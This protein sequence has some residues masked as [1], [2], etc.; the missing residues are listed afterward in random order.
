M[1]AFDDFRKAIADRYHV[2]RE[3]G[4]GGMATVYLAHDLRHDRPV[5]LKLL[6]PELGAV[7][8][9]ER[10]LREIRL[11]AKLQHPHILPL[12]DSGGVGGG[13]GMPGPYLFYVMPY[14][15]GESLRQLLERDKQLSIAEALR[16][17]TEIAE[18][19][20]YAHQQAVIHRDIKPEN[21]LLSQGHA[22][23]A[24]FGIALAVTQA[25]GGRL[26]ETGLSLGTPAYMSPEQA[27][28]EADLD[29]RTDQYSLACVLYEMLAGEPPYSGPTAQAIIAKRLREPVPHLSTIREVPAAVEMAVTRALAKAR[30]DRFSSCAEF[31]KALVA[32]AQ[33]PIRRR[34]SILAAAALVLV[35]ALV[36]ILKSLPHHSGPARPAP[37]SKNPEAQRLNERGYEALVRTS[38]NYYSTVD[39]DL[40]D[41]AASLFSR[42]AELDTTFGLAL[43]RLAEVESRRSDTASQTR[44]RAAATQAVARSP[45]LAEAHLALL[46]VASDSATAVAE[47]ARA[48]EL[49]PRNPEV[50]GRA[51]LLT[52]IYGGSDDE[53]NALLQR[54]LAADSAAFEVLIPAGILALTEGRYDE[55]GERFRQAI[56]SR[57]DS[58]DGYHWLAWRWQLTGDQL[59]SDS[60]FQQF[61]ARVGS[62]RAIELASGWPFFFVSFP[63]RYDATV[64]S[65]VADPRRGPGT[66]HLHLSRGFVQRRL[67]NT[68][69][70][71]ASFDSAVTIL[72]KSGHLPMLAVAQAAAGHAAVAVATARAVMDGHPLGIRQRQNYELA[73]IVAHAYVL[74]HEPD[75][76]I[77]ILER[78]VKGSWLVTPM[79]LRVDPFWAPLQSNFRFQQLVA[80]TG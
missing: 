48:L 43:A 67:G 77:D 13:P 22:L 4:A 47:L 15:E 70:A 73:Y 21:I 35:M 46:A 37:L 23:V 16:L 53:A 64:L 68:R 59:R 69:A 5:A 28:A 39:A 19:L 44:A 54:G 80:S 62:S 60:V 66:G 36:W 20:D 55:A 72:V 79:S 61:A 2:E 41:E 38:E 11:T 63:G 42:A 51:A 25:G 78:L 32:S 24:D 76:A 18:A 1:T 6:R 49:G 56:A 50:L 71:Q 75:A 17:T 58:Y 30:V 45:D 65:L 29:A 52:T 12:L 40:R 10:F 9:A 26:T 14:V 34:R 8:G 33:S 74:A 7:L 27:M 3:I 57:P 31:G